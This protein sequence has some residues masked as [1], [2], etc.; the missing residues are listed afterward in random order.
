MSKHT[1]GPW[2]VVDNGIWD[3]SVVAEATICHI[4]NKGE[5]FPK[6]GTQ[7]GRSQNKMLADARLIAAAPDL[8]EACQTFAE[9]LRR[10]EEGFVAAGRSRDT[11]EGEKEWREWFYG[12]IALCDLAQYQ[13]RAAIAKATG[14]A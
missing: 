13:A 3:V 5:W 9:W 12:N 7:M 1:P 2:A 10:E 11:P 14:E 6:D 4:N 8:L